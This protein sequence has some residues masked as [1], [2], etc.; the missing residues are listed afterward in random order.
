MHA[1]DV[2]TTN[3]VVVLADTPVKE[4]AGLLLKH[5]ISAVP[6]VD[7]E[8]RVIGIVSEGDLM[9]RPENEAE[10]RFSWWLDVFA[11]P[12]QKAAEYV[13]TH[14]LRASD[15]MTKDLFTVTEDTPLPEIARLLEKHHIKRTPVVR[16]DRLVGI[17]S[18]ANLLHGL[19]AK[20]A[21]NTRPASSDDRTIREKLLQALW[22]D[23]GLNKGLINVTVDDGI[24]QLWGIV[25]TEAQKKAA[26]VAAENT[27]GVKAIENHIGKLP[28][29]GWA[30]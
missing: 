18:R 13:K 23:V 7:A 14:G 25:E 15:V 8:Q 28:P 1:M 12:G 20:G 26:Q 17:V 6:V 27:A 10:A 11:S 22:K 3:V 9:R 29:W 19:V 2:M 30:G 21:E 5:R 16:D 4:I 24:V